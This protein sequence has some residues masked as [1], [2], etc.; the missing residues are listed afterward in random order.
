MKISVIAPP[1]IP[2]PPPGYG[3]IELVI[4]NLVEGFTKLGHE[5]IL[6]APEGSKVSCKLVQ[7]P[8]QT[9]K[10][11]LNSSEEDKAKLWN[12]SITFAY[13]ASK[14]ANVDIIHDHTLFLTDVNNIPTAHT[15]H[16]PAVEWLVELCAN[17]SSN[18]KNHLV[19]I[20]DRQKELYLEASDK[21][22]IA[23][24][25]HNCVDTENFEWT[26]DKE[27]YFFF[28]G[29]ANW[30]KGLDIAVRAASKSKVDLIMAVKMN[31]DF[32]KEFFKKEIQPVMDNYPDDC[33]LT[34]HE[35]ISR[36]LLD[37][38]YLKSK[39][40]LFPSQWEEPFGLVMIES[41]A[42]GTP[43]IAFNKGAAPEIIVHGKTG[44]IVET[45]EEFTAAIKKIDTI[46]PEAC[47][48]HVEENF[49]QAKMCQDY[50]AVY[51]K[52]LAG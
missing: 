12:S 7:G 26:K 40:T 32:E 19:A 33:K 25:V 45:E 43:V 11:T 17:L 39:G 24:T 16:G 14:D 8:G 46:D 18:P 4:Y 36:E 27:D 21:L 23:G 2:I 52:I 48:R 13:N 9:G 34:L 47:R 37:S 22:N 3:G 1:W 5:V 44:F 51:E 30:E 29:R 20:S 15:M 38:L 28:A 10:I 42:R 6:Y 35:E 41:M 50:L 31:E 49:S